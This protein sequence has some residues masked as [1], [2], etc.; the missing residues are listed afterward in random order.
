LK[1]TEENEIP[2]SFSGV[3]SANISVWKEMVR[4]WKKEENKNRTLKDMF[5][6]VRYS[7]RAYAEF[8]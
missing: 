7:A 3:S 8:F 2:S 5:S 6:E 4:R 1:Q